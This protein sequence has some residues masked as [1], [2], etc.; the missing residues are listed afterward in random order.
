MWVIC[1]GLF[2]SG[3]TWQYEVAN[4]LVET[5]RQGFGVGYVPPRDF[6]P[7][8]GKGR[9]RRTVD[10]CGT[11]RTFAENETKRPVT[12]ADERAA[13]A[14]AKAERTR[15]DLAAIGRLSGGVA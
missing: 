4:H 6:N 9:L 8:V 7:V 12:V 2:R 11:F 10:V 3:S 13:R 15:L 5:C 14:A 1:G